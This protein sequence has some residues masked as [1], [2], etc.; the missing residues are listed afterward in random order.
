MTNQKSKMKG[1]VKY[2]QE[3]ELNGISNSA[4]KMSIVK[5]NPDNKITMSNQ[6]RKMPLPCKVPSGIKDKNVKPIQYL[7]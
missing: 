1:G 4:N 2:C 7:L 6:F 5:Y 3:K